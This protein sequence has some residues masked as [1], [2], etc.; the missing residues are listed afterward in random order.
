MHRV[1]S[2]ND[3][4]LTIESK[5][6]MLKSQAFVKINVFEQERKFSN[7]S[8]DNKLQFNTKQS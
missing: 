2:F 8:V 4:I 7:M 3:N 1:D 6:M 5:K